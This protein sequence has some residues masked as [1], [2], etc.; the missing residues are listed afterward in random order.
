MG[1]RVALLLACLL[2]ASAGAQEVAVEEGEAEPVDEAGVSGGPL[3]LSHLGKRPRPDGLEASSPF[4]ED[5][6]WGLKESELRLVPAGSA[7]RRPGAED[8]SLAG[9]S[10]PGPAMVE[11]W[12]LG[13]AYTFPRLAPA[14]GAELFSFAGERRDQTVFGE[15]V[16]LSFYFVELAFDAVGSVGGE[17]ID[18]TDLDLDFR[19][20]IRL[21][22]KHRLAVMP[23]STFPIDGRDNTDDDTAI[24]FQLLYGIGGGGLGFQARVGFAQ[25][26]RPR[27]LLLFDEVATDPA[28]LYGA[29]LSWR[30]VPG[31]QLRAEASGQIG[32]DGGTDSLTLLGGPVF[33]P[34]G[35]PRVSLGTV[36]I[37]QTQATE[38]DFERP[39]WGGLVQVGVDFY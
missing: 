14:I 34:L 1:G 37:V 30:F 7:W 29:M 5:P 33:F 8:V 31:V 9:P 32:R 22:R 11:A 6:Y 19:I 3:D 20:P 36:G 24:R 28:F 35:D 17:R 15:R 13:A 26:S 25:G 4:E 2:P 39:V 18:R 10:W 23:G 12:D 38:L 16:R 27:G 21:G